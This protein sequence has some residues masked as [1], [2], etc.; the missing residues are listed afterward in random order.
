[1]KPWM[2]ILGGAALFIL[3]NGGETVENAKFQSQQSS[4]VSDARR[5]QRAQRL[6]A[7][8]AE[9]FASVSLDRIKAGC[10][11]V[12][13]P[14]DRANPSQGVIAGTILIEGMTVRDWDGMAFADGTLVCTEVNT[15]VVQS[16]AVTQVANVAPAD[17]AE[18]MMLFN[19][20]LARAY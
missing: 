8:T 15:G 20:L 1:M 18:Y 3:S 13:R 17:R 4:L 12:G 14:Q 2:L 10:I 6:E 19:Q 16:G 11:T 5:E 9:R 7:R